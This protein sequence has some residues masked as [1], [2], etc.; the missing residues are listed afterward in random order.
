MEQFIRWDVIAGGKWDGEQRRGLIPGGLKSN[1]KTNMIIEI[2]IEKARLWGRVCQTWSA[3]VLLMAGV[4][5]GVGGRQG[6][7]GGGGGGGEMRFEAAADNNA[8]ENVAKVLHEDPQERIGGGVA[9]IQEN[10]PPGHILTFHNNI[11]KH[12]ALQ[13]QTH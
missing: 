12:F 1:H 6:N 3:E 5:Y 2:K 10:H 11:L 7:R 13:A 8:H 9:I 4:G